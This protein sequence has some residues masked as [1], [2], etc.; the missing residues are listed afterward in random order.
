MRVTTVYK[1]K[2]DSTHTG[3]NFR[4]GVIS[5]NSLTWLQSIFH[6]KLSLL[7]LKPLSGF[8]KL[9]IKSKPGMK[10]PLT[11]TPTSGHPSSTTKLCLTSPVL[12][13]MEPLP[14]QGFC[15]QSCLLHS[16]SVL[17]QA[18]AG[19]PHQGMA[20]LVFHFCHFFVVSL[21]LY[22]QNHFF[23]E[24]RPKIKWKIVLL[25]HHF[26]PVLSMYW[27]LSMHLLSKYMNEW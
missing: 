17:R 12:Y 25:S 9:R 15:T 3:W 14:P 18:L 21:E 4:S 5:T 11:T 7:C 1:I 6:L 16:E 13:P 10:L 26:T 22:N 8:S 20:L 23:L 27:T 24:N 2:Y 19:L